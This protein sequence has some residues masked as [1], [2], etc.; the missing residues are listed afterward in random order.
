MEWPKV[1]K[2]DL[3]QPI[4][5]PLKSSVTAVLI[6]QLPPRR[7][8]ELSEMLLGTKLRLYEEPLRLKVRMWLIRSLCREAVRI[9]LQISLYRAKRKIAGMV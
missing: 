7:K 4:E 6:R 5:P 2:N 9:R 3:R 1:V 8:R